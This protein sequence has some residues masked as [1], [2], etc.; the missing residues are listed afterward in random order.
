M[1]LILLEQMW[2]VICVKGLLFNWCSEDLCLL[3]KFLCV[4]WRCYLLKRGWK[5]PQPYT[6]GSDIRMF[7]SKNKVMGLS[8]L[9]SKCSM[10]LIG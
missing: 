1:K 9:F 7:I 10:I 4:S 3:L 2:V 5:D 8:F 6:C